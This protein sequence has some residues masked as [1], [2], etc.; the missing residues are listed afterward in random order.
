VVD[1]LQEV[2]GDQVLE[3][4]GILGRQGPVEVIVLRR[5]LDGSDAG[6]SEGGEGR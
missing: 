4:L 1:P 2:G 6:G 3:A 5:L